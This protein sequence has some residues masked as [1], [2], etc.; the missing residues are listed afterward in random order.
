M[1]R[2]DEPTI[3]EELG[4]LP[5]RLT[6]AR[7]LAGLH[8]KELSLLA[9]LAQGHAGMVERGEMESPSIRTVALLAEVLGLSMDWI[10]LGRGKPPTARS[11]IAAV[12]KFRAEQQAAAA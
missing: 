8:L 5:G 6:A 11:V 3:T 4:G 7:G 2:E 10:V 1:T 9:G 12:A